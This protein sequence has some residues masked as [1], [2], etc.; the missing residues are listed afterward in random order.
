ME[1]NETAVNITTYV[2]QETNKLLRWAMGRM[3]EGQEQIMVK[4]GDEKK[5]M[6]K[7]AG[8]K[9]E[10]ANLTVCEMASHLIRHECQ[11]KEQSYP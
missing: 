5:Q 1:Q 2:D 4:R 7:I 9:T 6:W 3:P 8:R 10:S 11:Q